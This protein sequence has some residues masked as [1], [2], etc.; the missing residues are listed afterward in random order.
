MNRKSLFIFIWAVLS[1]WCSRAQLA[2]PSGQGWE[3]RM[4]Q[5]AR[6]Y[7]EGD[8]ESALQQ[9]LLAL[10]GA[11]QSEAL[12]QAAESHYL[13]GEI[14]STLKRYDEAIQHARRGL[15]MRSESLGVDH[16]QVGLSANSLAQ[17]YQD[18]GNFEKAL[19]LNEQAITIWR[20]HFGKT[21]PH[22]AVPYNNQGRILNI[23]GKHHE[24][25]AR[26]LQADGHEANAKQ[27][28]DQAQECYTQALSYFRDAESILKSL[29][30]EGGVNLG[31]C[32]QNMADTQL[33]LGQ[34]E[35]AE[36]TY[37]HALKILGKAL[38]KEEPFVI[39]CL[40]RLAHVTNRLDK[41]AEAEIFYQHALKYMSEN[42]GGD[43]RQLIELLTDMS[44]FYEKIGNEEKAVSCRAGATL[45]QERQDK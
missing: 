29:P 23:L 44:A 43:E 9:S 30:E 7:G 21:H 22:L 12:I 4:T 34:L 6:L 37:R 27:A 40:S 45:I 2:N 13:L 3:A 39:L 19:P 16:V 38:G 32:Y 25:N 20:I 26:H 5:A 1:A 33:A 15:L 28:T 42:V 41:N 24:K 35:D 31:A 11:Q 17:I 18:Q 36:Q 14:Y 8:L 10:E